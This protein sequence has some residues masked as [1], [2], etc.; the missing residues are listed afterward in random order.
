MT[1]DLLLPVV[2]TLQIFP[3]FSQGANPACSPD[4]SFMATGSPDCYP[5]SP[6]CST[7]LFPL[8]LIGPIMCLTDE[9]LLDVEKG[10]HAL[11]KHAALLHL[12]YKDMEP[13]SGEYSAIGL[14]GSEAEVI[15]YAEH[16]DTPSNLVSAPQ[17]YLLLSQSCF[18]PGMAF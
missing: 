8:S 16:I 1:K 14:K 12:V 6:T 2:P 18:F 10:F 5:A 15:L 7:E 13:N 11:S 9:P 4:N 3:L 17:S